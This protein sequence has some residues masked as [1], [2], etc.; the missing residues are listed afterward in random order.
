MKFIHFTDLHLVPPGETLWGN[1]PFE[2]LNAC[3]SD[4]AAH[5]PD[6]EFGD[7]AGRRRW[8]HDGG[9]ARQQGGC[10]LFEHAPDGEIVG[11]DVNR[12]TMKRCADVLT[13]K[14]PTA[15]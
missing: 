7:I 10:Q 1:N 15:A 8:L 14:C 2:R 6:A 12:H 5:H 9:H 3:L 13:N 11:V 4:I